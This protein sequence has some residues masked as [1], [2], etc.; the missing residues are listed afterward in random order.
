M[1]FARRHQVRRSQD[2]TDP[3][4]LVLQFIKFIHPAPQIT[5]KIHPISLMLNS[6]GKLQAEPMDRVFADKPP[7]VYSDSIPYP[8][9][10]DTR[11]SAGGG[12]RSL[13]WGHASI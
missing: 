6:D 4:E 13:P 2:P 7:S 1:E 10:H 5:T 3:L 11:S 9:V 8:Y 12:P